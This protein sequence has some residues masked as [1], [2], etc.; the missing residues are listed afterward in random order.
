MTILKKLELW[1]SERCNGRWEHEFGV[2]VDTLDNPG[3]CVTIGLMETPWELEDW[4]PM[5]IDNG[6]NDWVKCCKEGAQFRGNGDPQ[7]L[8][9]ILGWFLDKVHP[10]E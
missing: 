7:K 9:I 4:S 8:E 5:D 10:T 1:Y 2:L 6:P 3:W